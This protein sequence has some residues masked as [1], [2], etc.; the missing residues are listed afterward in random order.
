MS[1]FLGQVRDAFSFV[2]RASWTEIGITSAFGFIAAGVFL[3]SGSIPTILF[4]AGF[5]VTVM[6]AALFVNDVIK[7]LFARLKVREASEKAM[8]KALIKTTWDLVW[9]PA[10]EKVDA[11]NVIKGHT[12]KANRARAIYAGS[13]AANIKAGNVPDGAIEALALALSR[14]QGDSD[15]AHVARAALGHAFREALQDVWASGQADSLLT[16]LTDNLLA[17]LPS[18]SPSARSAK[19]ELGYMLHLFPVHLAEA[20]VASAQ[21]MKLAN[22]LEVQGHDGDS[23][24]NVQALSLALYMFKESNVDAAVR[25]KAG[26]ALFA[27]LSNVNKVK[28]GSAIVNETRRLLMESLNR[29]VTTADGVSEEILRAI[30]KRRA[31]ARMDSRVE[32]NPTEPASR[33]Q[34]S[35]SI[36]GLMQ[37]A[38]ID[39]WQKRLSEIL[40]AGIREL[41]L[42]TVAADYFYLYRTDPKAPEAGTHIPSNWIRDLADRAGPKSLDG[43]S[44]VELQYTKAYNDA[45]QKFWDGELA[46]VAYSQDHKEGA[47]SG[48]AAMLSVLWGDQGQFKVHVLQERQTAAVHRIPT[49][50][51]A[52]RRGSGDPIRNWM[53]GGAEARERNIRLMVNEKRQLGK[54]SSIAVTLLKIQGNQALVIVDWSAHRADPEGDYGGTTGESNSQWLGVGGILETFEG[55]SQ[56]GRVVAIGKNTVTINI[57]TP[58]RAEARGAVPVRLLIDLIETLPQ[59]RDRKLGYQ[60]DMEAAQRFLKIFLVQKL[61]EG[62]RAE[63]VYADINALLTLAKEPSARDGLR[64]LM[65]LG[66]NIPG[67][68]EIPGPEKEKPEEGP[69]TKIGRITGFLIGGFLFTIVALVQL[70]LFWIPV[71]LVGGAMHFVWSMIFRVVRIFTGND[72]LEKNLSEY[73]D[74]ASGIATGLS[75]LASVFAAM[76]FQHSGDPRL[77]FGAG[78]VFAVSAL[79][80]IYQAAKWEILSFIRN[81]RQFLRDGMQYREPELALPITESQPLVRL[82]VRLTMALESIQENA[83]SAFDGEAAK[84]LQ[85]R[86]TE[87]IKRMQD[88][89]TASHLQKLL[90]LEPEAQEAYADTVLF[91]VRALPRL[92]MPARF[93]ARDFIALET[94]L[95]LIVVEKHLGGISESKFEE[96]WKLRDRM[97][98]VVALL[99]ASDDNV[100]LLLQ[101]W[102]SRPATVDPK[103][104]QADAKKIYQ[105]TRHFLRK[106]ENPIAR[107]VVSAHRAEVR[108][109]GSEEIPGLWDWTNV[110]ATREDLG[111]IREKAAEILEKL[112]AQYDGSPVFE[113]ER[114]LPALQQE[115]FE[116]AERL[117]RAE[118]G[119]LTTE[120][121]H[122]M[123]RGEVRSGQAMVQAEA[124][125]TISSNAKMLWGSFRQYYESTPPAWFF[126]RWGSGLANYWRDVT[127]NGVWEMFG[128]MWFS[129]PLAVIAAAFFYWVGFGILSPETSGWL[130]AVAGLSSVPFIAIFFKFEPLRPWGGLIFSAVSV[131]LPVLSLLYG[132]VLT[133][134]WAVSVVRSGV[135]ETQRGVLRRAIEKLLK[136][137]Q[138]NDEPTSA[139][140]PQMPF[141]GKSHPTLLAETLRWLQAGV[142][143]RDLKKEITSA[144]DFLNRWGNYKRDLSERMEQDPDGGSW[145]AENA[146]RLYDVVSMFVLSLE[147]YRAFLRNREAA[148]RRAEVRNEMP[149]AKAREGSGIANFIYHGLPLG[150]YVV[151]RWISPREIPGELSHAY[152]E[153]D[154]SLNAQLTDELKAAGWPSFAASFVPRYLMVMHAVG[155]FF[156]GVGQRM[157]RAQARWAMR[158]Q[159]PEFPHRVNIEQKVRADIDALT[160]AADL[161]EARSQ[162]EK[163]LEYVK[164]HGYLQREIRKSMME[165]ERMATAADQD[166]AVLSLLSAIGSLTVES[167][168]NLRQNFGSHGLDQYDT[169][170]EETNGFW[171]IPEERKREIQSFLSES[172]RGAFTSQADPELKEGSEIEFAKR[173]NA[174]TIQLNGMY[175]KYRLRAEVRTALSDTVQ[176]LNFAVFSD[177]ANRMPGTAKLPALMRYLPQM[178]NEV[179]EAMPFYII[180]PLSIV[181]GDPVALAPWTPDF[182]AYAHE[183]IDGFLKQRAKEGQSS[184]PL[185][186][187]VLIIPRETEQGNASPHWMEKVENIFYAPPTGERP[188]RLLIQYPEE[189]GY[190][191]YQPRRE[192]ERSTMIRESVQVVANEGNGR[193]RVR[194]D[195]GH[196]ERI[197]LQLELPLFTPVN[198]KIGRAEV[199]STKDV[200]LALK[201][202]SMERFL[203]PMAQEDV[204]GEATILEAYRKDPARFRAMAQGVYAGTFNTDSIRHTLR[205]LWD[206]GHKKIVRAVRKAF[207]DDPVRFAKTYMSLGMTS[208]QFIAE[209]A[210]RTEALLKEAKISPDDLE[211]F[212]D[213]AGV[214]YPVT[215]R[216]G[217]PPRVPAIP[218]IRKIL[219]KAFVET[220]VRSPQSSWA[221]RSETAG[222]E[223]EVNRI[224]EKIFW[225]ARNK[226]RAEIRNETTPGFEQWLETQRAGQ[227]ALKQQLLDEASKASDRSAGPYPVLEQIAHANFRRTQEAQRRE[228][229]G[230]SGD[231]EIGLL[232]ATPRW[233]YVPLRDGSILLRAPRMPEFSSDLAALYEAL[234]KWDAYQGSEES[235]RR[236]LRETIFI[237]RENSDGPYGVRRAETLKA[238]LKAKRYGPAQYSYGE[239]DTRLNRIDAVIDEAAQ[240]SRRQDL[241]EWENNVRGILLQKIADLEKG[242]RAEARTQSI[243]ERGAEIERTY[244]SFPGGYEQYFQTSLHLHDDSIEAGTFRAVGA[245]ENFSGNITDILT[246]TF[247]RPFRWGRAVRA[248]IEA[249]L[250]DMLKKIGIKKNAPFRIGIDL[251]VTQARGNAYHYKWQ[252]WIDS[253]RTGRIVLAEPEL[254][255]NPGD[256]EPAVEDPHFEVYRF[257]AVLERLAETS[258]MSDAISGAIYDTG[259]GRSADIAD[260]LSGL[261][262]PSLL[263]MIARNVS[264]V[265]MRDAAVRKLKAYR[266]EI[267]PEDYSDE[268]LKQVED[269]IQAVGKITLPSA[270]AEV[271]VQEAAAALTAA[272]QARASRQLQVLQKAL[273]KIRP[274]L[275]KLR[276]YVAEG[277]RAAQNI[278]KALGAL[279]R[280]T[281]LQGLQASELDSTRRLLMYELQLQVTTEALTVWTGKGV[282]DYLLFEGWRKET[283]GFRKWKGQTKK[284][285]IQRR[286]AMKDRLR[287]FFREQSP[288]GSPSFIREGK[289]IAFASLLVKI[290]AGLEAIERRSR[291][292]A[293]RA[294]LIRTV[295]SELRNLQEFMNPEELAKVQ[296]PSVNNHSDLKRILTLA[297]ER[298]QLYESVSEL[299]TDPQKTDMLQ[300]L[301]ELSEIGPMRRVRDDWLLEVLR[302]YVQVS[303]P[304]DPN[305]K[306]GRVY[307]S[308][309]YAVHDIG[310]PSLLE[311]VFEEGNF[312]LSPFSRIERIVKDIQDFRA[313]NN[314][315][316]QEMLGAP[317]PP[318]P[319][320]AEVRG[321][322]RP[323]GTITFFTGDFDAFIKNIRAHFHAMELIFRSSVIVFL[324]TEQS[325]EEMRTWAEELAQELGVI[326][327]AT[328]E[329]LLRNYIQSQLLAKEQYLFDRAMELFKAAHQDRRSTSTQNGAYALVVQLGADR[330]QSIERVLTQL[331]GYRDLVAFMPASGPFVQA[332]EVNVPENV[333]VARLGREGNYR[334]IHVLHG[335]S[336]ENATVAPTIQDDEIIG[337]TS[338][339]TFDVAVRDRDQV[340][341]VS[342][343]MLDVLEE[344]IRA[345]VGLKA[346]E[347]IKDKGV[348]LEA[349]LAN[350][351]LQKQVRNELFLAFFF[352]KATELDRDMIEM[353]VENGR[354]TIGVKIAGF[355]ARLTQEFTN[356][357]EVR[358]AA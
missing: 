186:T 176:A 131:L 116:K 9:T 29:F 179:L 25:K 351:A 287:E 113:R 49:T 340:A 161:K 107:A 121:I 233:S 13:L 35:G 274:G 345:E 220:L 130:K 19:Y 240:V 2:R 324:G 57:S 92:K 190:Y 201:M 200:I 279:E 157:A 251:L 197:T 329:V 247:D 174:I 286:E 105:E 48:D 265:A 350:P 134:P 262:D 51:K 211:A 127:S 271:R 343:T 218:K 6:M 278:H 129:V 355:V 17:S 214:I 222:T 20:S 257:L 237:S 283:K 54:G 185:E 349:F 11:L 244:G 238:I 300:K 52:G 289:E 162:M 118:H 303:E 282:P 230:L 234:M 155:S 143:V 264:P 163:L 146:R 142:A 58:V 83:P 295:R 79:E 15:A 119:I 195:D 61:K 167:L 39:D 62:K 97:T 305:P 325:V 32:L 38:R 298:K 8:R 292:E 229:P 226:T 133:V 296:E 308:Y 158:P 132:V 297:K 69:W 352:M 21:A 333:Q 354:L 189:Y 73:A 156:E 24:E 181:N 63:N 290:Q 187:D 183:I 221:A 149:R 219:V 50:Q 284:E 321:G 80:W 171:Q 152:P 357:A 291:A 266:Q 280:I 337:V 205:V 154:R 231:Q 301:K 269:T 259:A 115:A 276:S 165:M 263:A 138:K 208:E 166:E 293:R 98:R 255:K 206:N 42:A 232:V 27:Q 335:Q 177:V 243:E 36:R 212:A 327:V 346:S 347:L 33:F 319:G 277:S 34:L 7:G 339:G 313:A 199:R 320:R 147:S 136:T 144:Q 334:A 328:F 68:R 281:N 326:K 248:S 246:T 87:M 77:L 124:E 22:A 209:A 95:D 67:L 159:A 75:F 191:L 172:F 10:A 236:S 270:R 170:N 182:L 173:L 5:A 268:E 84:T 110:K 272:G 125:R 216:Q 40:P 90:E 114:D 356:R 100:A 254:R 260:D 150:V 318:R 261:V 180:H 307:E 215:V 188:A 314:A 12:D 78:S 322:E 64:Q 46:L 140:L 91:L 213:Y 126:R 14:V 210:E 81:G 178:D 294:A 108:A 4:G 106:L 93:F 245:E 207:I 242:R 225:E 250:K 342:E 65:S 18:N 330:K 103:K 310:S 148:V 37:A 258:W 253:K 66:K 169:M 202:P 88:H 30:A 117:Y 336:I 267:N 128:N 288:L 175:E 85:A 299:L 338:K 109:E 204:L 323:S 55:R 316:R 145:E 1:G 141:V 26:E 198:E 239:Q 31:E 139:K 285:T 184:A 241:P 82:Q 112:R 217:R 312:R 45:Y 341:G 151:N 252:I 89:G 99:M 123:T 224:L 344:L 227:E 193:Y 192:N 94:L 348:S 96:A 120:D 306:E 315:L 47:P 235:E 28:E 122:D 137:V 228:T 331:A 332:G 309:Y 164:P 74:A 168:S 249:N 302:E 275:E 70:V 196:E 43:L 76:H 101:P 71:S 16:L 59:W 311:V 256:K 60:K 102:A 317:T 273:A 135:I 23:M 3:T 194:Y 304:T 223:G 111:A 53:S 153:D 41:G 56:V 44:P 86:L 203:I 353:K 104:L 358:K 160:L 72:N